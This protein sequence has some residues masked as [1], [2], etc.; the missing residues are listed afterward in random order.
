MTRISDINVKA[1]TANPEAVFETPTELADVVGLTRAQRL[2]ALDSWA[3]TVRARVDAVSEG[4]NNIPSNA[5][6]N[7]VELLREIERW[8]DVLAPK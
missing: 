6:N 3:F 7:D 5:Y 2:T 8:R 1:A 4:M